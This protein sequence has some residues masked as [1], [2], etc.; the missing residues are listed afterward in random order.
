MTYIVLHLDIAS[1]DPHR[2]IRL[3]I[4]QLISG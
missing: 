2:I 1:H 3:C 4:G